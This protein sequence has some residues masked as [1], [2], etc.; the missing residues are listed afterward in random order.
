MKRTILTTIGVI[1]VGAVLAGCSGA[2]GGSGEDGGDTGTITYA[3]WDDTQKPAM[4]EI[5]TAFEADHPGVKVEIQLT[6]W[7]DYWTKMQTA[8]TG[9]SGPDVMWMHAAQIGLYASQN[10]LAPLSGDG[11]DTSKYPEALVNTYTYDGKLY[12]VPKDYDTVA[13]WYNKK[14]FAD[15]GVQPPTTD[16]TWADMQAAAKKL[17]TGDV[18][19][20]ASSAARQQNVYPAI[21]SAGGDVVSPD[22]TKSGYGSPE[23]LAGVEFLLSFIAD[24]SSPTMQQMVDTSPAESFTSGKI[25]MYLTASNN[26]LFFKKST[27]AAD[28]QVA[29]LPKGPA[30]SIS[31]INGLANS[32][33]A[34]S[35]HLKLAQEFAAFASG[36]KAAEI[37][38]DSGTVIPAYEGTSEA[39]VKA[40]PE[41]DLQVFIDAAATA[42]PYPT[43]L[44]RAKWEKAEDDMMPKIWTGEVTAADGLKDLAKQ[45]QD[46]L[47][48]EKK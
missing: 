18:K 32:V 37:Q 5:A 39:W 42:K 47:D 7:D 28:L 27:A 41:Y 3:I 23:A 9:G 16:W 48:T 34:S 8:M 2:S 11:I 4:Q 24:G 43:T 15:A 29:P 13:L 19:G 33:N 22:G 38:A 40:I 44:D 25:A 6:P 20:F 45:M 30:G 21:F 35:K 1:A 46:V 31:V 14:L 26:A 12:G 17:T 10:Q 36:Q